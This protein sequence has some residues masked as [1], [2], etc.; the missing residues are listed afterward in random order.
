MHLEEDL[1]INE[2]RRNGFTNLG[3]FVYYQGFRGPIKIWE[4]NYPSDIEF[5]EEYL[6][7]EYADIAINEAKPGEY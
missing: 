6:E 4:V 3:N 2:L 1:I 7:I 5:K